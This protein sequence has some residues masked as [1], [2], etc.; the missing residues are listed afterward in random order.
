MN[1]KYVKS[2]LILLV[3][4]ADILLLRYCYHYYTTRDY[5]DRMTA[6]DA[7]AILAADGIEVSPDLLAVRADSAPARRCTYTREDY[8]RLVLGLLTDAE[9]DGIF[10]L[11]DGIRAVTAAGDVALLG[12]DLSLCFTAAD[13]DTD[14]LAAEYAKSYAATADTEAPRRALEA[15]LGLAEGGAN[16][17]PATTAGGYVFFTV[18]AEAGGIPLALDDCVFAYLGTKLVYAKGGYLF[19]ATEALDAE[20][21]LTRVNILLSE[22]RRGATGTVTAVTLCYAP[23]EDAAESALW[24]FPAYRVTY[25]DGSVSVVHAQSGEKY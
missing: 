18:S 20:P 3:A 17:I 15:L 23:Y 14:A 6:E 13:R 12:N 25:A 4:L 11:P 9:I 5:T 24:L 2:F 1:W 8:A 21:L 19:L 16:G 10:L 7:A 22:R